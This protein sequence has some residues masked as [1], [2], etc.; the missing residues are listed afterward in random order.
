MCLLLYVN[1]SPTKFCKT[2]KQQ[3]KNTDPGAGKGNTGA[4]KMHRA[5]EEPIKNRRGN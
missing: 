4:L 3:E 1:D 2:Y 5:Y